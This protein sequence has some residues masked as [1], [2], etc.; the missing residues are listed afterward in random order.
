MKEQALI[1]N[2][3][4]QYPYV[5]E[6]GDGCNAV[7]K[8][9]GLYVKCNNSCKDSYCKI[10]SLNLYLVNI[11]ER[12]VGGFTEKTPH[13]FIKMNCYKKTIKKMGY[14]IRDL[15]K[16]ARHLNL[17]LNMD[18]VEEMCKIKSKHKT[19]KV[20]NK[21]DVS[22]VNDT[23]D[24]DEPRV[25]RGRGRPKNQ[26]VK[27]SDDL[28]DALIQ[29]EDQDDNDL[30]Y[31]DVD[32]IIVEPFEYTGNQDEFKTLSLYIDSNDI[33]YNNIGDI[34]GNYYPKLNMIVDR[35]A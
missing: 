20:K 3:L 29:C 1:Q 31:S 10:C 32:E 7:V 21:Q 5:N 18:Y 30:E 4:L 15:K 22:I 14:T 33:I 9:N 19:K 2:S 27:N 17:S 24:E 13:N 12:I 28:I 8:R 25:V 26:N 6:F 35:F 34:L 23:D 16:Q 11:K